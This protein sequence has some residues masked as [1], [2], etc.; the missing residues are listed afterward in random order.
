M[1][2]LLRQNCLIKKTINH[3]M[4]RT[5][6]TNQQ[7]GLDRF[8]KGKELNQHLDKGLFL[9]FMILNFLFKLENKKKN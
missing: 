4:V 2:S 1:F 7:I 5:F 8:L 9:I 6:L 3:Q